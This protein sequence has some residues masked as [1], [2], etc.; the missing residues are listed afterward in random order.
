MNKSTLVTL[1]D[2]NDEVS[3]DVEQVEIQL[4]IHL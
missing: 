2:S 1:G 3:F 4:F